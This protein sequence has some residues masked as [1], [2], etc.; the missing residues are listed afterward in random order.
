MPNILRIIS[1]V[2]LNMI[3]KWII[4]FFWR[5]KLIMN[6]KINKTNYFVKLFTRRKILS[7]RRR[8]TYL[9]ECR[10]NYLWQEDEKQKAGSTQKTSKEKQ[11][12]FFGFF[13]LTGKATSF[14]GPLIY[15]IITNFYSQQIALWVVVVFF[16]IG[17]LLFNRIDFKQ[18]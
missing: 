13:A 11:N 2:C 18:K 4:S 6:T 17:L 10:W 8:N 14:L 1:T 12:E 3:Y 16:V 5:S 15:G 7:H 9:S